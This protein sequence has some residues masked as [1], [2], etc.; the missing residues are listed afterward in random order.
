MFDDNTAEPTRG[1][2]AFDSQ[3]NSITAFPC[4]HTGSTTAQIRHSTIFQRDKLYSL[5]PQPTNPA[6]RELVGQ[7]GTD[8]A[9]SAYE[10]L[11]GYD[12]VIHFTEV[13]QS[14]PA[15]STY[16]T[17]VL[18]NLVNG[19]NITSSGQTSSL[20]NVTTDG[21]YYRNPVNQNSYPGSLNDYSHYAVG[22]YWG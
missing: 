1:R 16:Y 14:F 4:A 11:P 7:T 21:S 18:T 8:D 17:Y 13:L 12:G 22:N 5:T 10:Y 3:G 15:W 19:T 6:L 20:Y 9:G 2:V